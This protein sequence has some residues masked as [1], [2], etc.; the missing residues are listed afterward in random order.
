MTGAPGSVTFPA[1]FGHRCA[2]IAG[3]RPSHSP[4]PTRPMVRPFLVALAAVALV[5]CGGGSDATEP[6][7]TGARV[8]VIHLIP[9][10]PVVDLRINDALPDALRAVAFG[11]A[12]G[13]QATSARPTVITA[14]VAPSTS[15]SVPVPIL[16]TSR[17]DLQPRTD[18]TFVLTGRTAPDATT[19]EQPGFTPYIDDNGA[20]PAGTTR[21]RVIHGIS[22]GGPVDVY[23]L[24][25]GTTTVPTTATPLLAGMSFRSA[26]AATP[27]AGSYALL[28]TRAGE[29]ATLLLR[30]DNVTLVAGGGVTVLARGFT[31]PG[32]PLPQ[33]P[34]LQIVPDR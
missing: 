22:D 26:R 21:V 7:I 16:L 31:R 1:V 11:G 2:A 14:Q 29:R 3:T 30:Q 19:D 33:Q 9:D 23:A 24:P 28:V 8:R 18:Y 20:P 12:P 15:P 13:Y 34:A 32:T 6:T 5:A 17:I 25:V 4:T 10:G 27:T